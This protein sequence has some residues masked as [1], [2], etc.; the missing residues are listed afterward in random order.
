MSWL[1]KISSTFGISQDSG[2]SASASGSTISGVPTRKIA[3]DAKQGADDAQR[4]VKVV[5]W[6]LVFVMGA[7]LLNLIFLVSD[8]YQFTRSQD[9]GSDDVRGLKADI[10]R[11]ELKNELLEDEVSDLKSCL[12]RGAWKACF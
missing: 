2:D 6:L 3:E 5:F 10:Y 11:L 1:K 8:Y 4:A 7:L 9:T 12:D